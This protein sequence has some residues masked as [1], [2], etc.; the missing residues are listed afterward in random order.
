MRYK[1]F[2]EDNDAT[3]DLSAEEV[4]RYLINNCKFYLEQI[5]YNVNLFALY[6]GSH[7]SP[8]D[9]LVTHKVRLSD[10]NPLNSPSLYHNIANDY[11]TKKFGEPFRN[12]L[13]VTSDESEAAEYTGRTYGIPRIVFPEG[14]FTFI[15]SPEVRDLFTDLL[16]GWQYEDEAE[17]DDLPEP[18]DERNAE[19]ANRFPDGKFEDELERNEYQDTNL[20]SAIKSKNEIMIRCKTYASVSIKMIDQIQAAINSELKR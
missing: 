13:F 20:I 3:K 9:S 14:I 15:W 19:I 18:T 7:D 11:F 8:H 12:A 17:Y 10:R 4:A 5:N 6:R 2:S 16:D 1:E